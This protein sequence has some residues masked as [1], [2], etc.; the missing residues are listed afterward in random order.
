MSCS[1]CRDGPLRTHGEIPAEICDDCDQRAVNKSGD[2]PW[3]GYPP[4]K[5]PD[6]DQPTVEPPDDGENPVFIDGHKCWRRYRFGGWKTFLDHY[7]CDTLDEFYIRHGLLDP[8]DPRDEI[9]STDKLSEEGSCTDTSTTDSNQ[10]D[11]NSSASCSGGP[12]TLE[13]STDDREQLLSLI[14]QEVNVSSDPAAT[15]DEVKRIAE[16][17]PDSPFTPLAIRYLVILAD[18]DPEAALDGLPIVASSYSTAEANVRQWSMY[19]FARISASYPDSL[20]P[21]LDTLIEGVTSENTNIQSNALA[22]LGRIVS[23]YPSA[24][25]GLVGE[26]ATLVIHDNERIRTNA[27]GLLGDIAHDHQHHVA[28][29]IATIA[30]CLTDE[31]PTVRRNASITLVRCGEANPELIRQQHERLEIA[32]ADVLPEVRKNACVLI[33]NAQPSIETA[34]LEEIVEADPDP[35]VEEMALWA[36]NQIDS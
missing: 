27:I 15:N 12:S 30:T 4:E 8:R 13:H 31:N 16:L 35:E 14:R 18:D 20:L 9:I 34:K 1:I 6:E 11:Q 21:I 36:L 17:I 33:G 5:R 26:L 25:A 24:G 7:D 22:T 3:H 23:E 32:L 10:A 29:H 2:T 19:Y 28:V